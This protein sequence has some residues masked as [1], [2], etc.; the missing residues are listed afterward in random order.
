MEGNDVTDTHRCLV[1]LR[2]DLCSTLS[3]FHL[4]PSKITWTTTV[5]IM[6]NKTA[7]VQQ[8]QFNN[9]H[10][11]LL[12]DPKLRSSNHGLSMQMVIAIHG[13]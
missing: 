3:F 1:S 6:Y 10:H 7:K 2:T 13:F 8:E 9:Y 4:L 12:S 11:L 5:I